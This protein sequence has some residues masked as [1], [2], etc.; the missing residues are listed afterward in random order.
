MTIIALELLHQHDGR[1]GPIVMPPFVSQ[2]SCGSGSDCDSL[3]GAWPDSAN[4]E[5]ERH[6][7]LV[8]ASVVKQSRAFR[9][10]ALDCRV[11]CG[12]SQ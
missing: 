8:I 4:R 7:F 2:R 9:A 1:K 3:A 5:A 12:S 10:L 6:L 11:A